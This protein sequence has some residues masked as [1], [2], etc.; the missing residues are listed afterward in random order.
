MKQILTQK[1]RPQ[2]RI[3][4]ATPSLVTYVEHLISTDYN[5]HVQ[6]SQAEA[7]KRFTRGCVT[8]WIKEG[9]IRRHYSGNK[10]VFYSMRELLRAATID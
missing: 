3:L 2:S 7:Y 6:L 5:E 8:R 10:S 4:R 1:I 9:K